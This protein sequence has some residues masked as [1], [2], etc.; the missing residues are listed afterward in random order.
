[1]IDHPSKLF[2]CDC[3]G[4]GL[5]V[6]KLY[7]DEDISE[8]EVLV[9]EDKKLRDCQEAPFIQLSFWEYGCCNNPKYFSNLWWRLKIA[10]YVFREG[11]PY[12]DQ[13]I[14]KAAVARNLANHI[15][16]MIAKGKKEMRLAVKQPVLVK[17]ESKQM[18]EIKEIDV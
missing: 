4:E 18:E 10:W 2:P 8:G 7:D 17:E 1:M 9:S 3:K 11:T 6:S 16:Y 15:L 13:V 5:T 14:M 12:T